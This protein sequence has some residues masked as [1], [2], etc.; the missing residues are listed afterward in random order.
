MA[1]LIRN[2]QPS[3]PAVVDKPL[4]PALFRRF[5]QET[6]LFVGFLLLLF[7]LAAMISHD[8]ADPA[9]STTG[10]RDYTENWLGPLGAWISDISYFL[11][12]RSVWMLF[13]AFAGAWLRL[14]RSWMRGEVPR[15][16]VAAQAPA[17]ASWRTRWLG[18][19]DRRLL[20]WLDRKSVV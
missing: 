17:A 18:W 3:T 9:W 4:V 1:Y 14:L 6:A 10:T 11:A 12:G 2:S 7:W 19:I 13:A 15:Q 20:W 5:S 16:A 8:I